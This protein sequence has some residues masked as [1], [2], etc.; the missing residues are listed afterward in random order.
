[1]ARSAAPSIQLASRSITPLASTYWRA[2][3]SSSVPLIGGLPPPGSML[4]SCSATF[5]M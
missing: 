4:A 1:M 5:S 2:S 3:S